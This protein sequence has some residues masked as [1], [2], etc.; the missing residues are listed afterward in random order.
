MSHRQVDVRQP[1]SSL[2]SSCSFDQSQNVDQTRA[3]AKE[4]Q[5][6]VQ[7][8]DIDTPIDIEPQFLILP[9]QTLSQ[10]RADVTADV[11]TQLETHQPEPKFQAQ[12]PTLT[13][14]RDLACAAL[15]V[16]A[17]KLRGGP[18]GA[19]AGGKDR[20]GRHQLAEKNEDMER[21]GDVD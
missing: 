11:L 14:W 12:T 2:S 3:Q 6:L 9:A 10:S 15:D 16:V 18:A 5:H 13:S 7:A 19:A 8:P 17:Y 21:D 4:T 1:L 20:G